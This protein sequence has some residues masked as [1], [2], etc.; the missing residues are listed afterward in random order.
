[1]STNIF[2]IKTHVFPGQYIREYPSATLNSQEEPL[3]LHIK[4]YIPRDA[5]KAQTGAV[6]IIAAH[7][8]GFIKVG[9]SIERRTASY[10]F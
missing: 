9:I 6:T 3:Q 10:A 4:Q 7:A 1:M 8:N 2:H 5:S